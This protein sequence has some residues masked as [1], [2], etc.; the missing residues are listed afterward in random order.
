MEQ[1]QTTIKHKKKDKKPIYILIGVFVLF[2]LFIFLITRQ[3][4]LGKA[5]DQIKVCNSVTD[6]K[7]LFDKYKFD[8]L[9][10]DENGGKI[11]A[12][13]FQS[14]VRDKLNSFNL[15]ED[16]INECLE[17]LPPAQTNINLIVIPD[18]S[19]RITDSVNNPNQIQ[20][21]QLILNKIWQT[22]V[23]TTKLKKDSKDKI[24][25][26]VTDID[27]AKGQFGKFAN[28]LQFDLSTHKGQSNRLFFTTDKDKQFSSN[29]I[30]MYN[31]ARQK[32][33]GADYLF[34][35]RRYLVNHL[36]K[37]TLYDNYINKVIIITDG[38]LEAEDRAPDTKLTPQLYNSVNRS[39]IKEMIKEL[40]LNIP[41][42]DIDLSNTDVLV[43]EV[44]ERK[45]GKAKDFEILKAYWEDWLQRMG[46]NSINFIQREQA[47]DVTLKRVSDFIKYKKKVSSKINRTS[48]VID[49]NTHG[50]DNEL[51]PELE[52]TLTGTNNSFSE[53]K[54]AKYILIE[55]K[56]NKNLLNQQSANLQSL[57]KYC[58]EQKIS[59]EEVYKATKDVDIKQRLDFYT[60][61]IQLFDEK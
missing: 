59:A 23:E 56:Q 34:Y 42:V 44:N 1:Y 37:P 50:R 38:Y 60:E 3:S 32:P 12:L 40:G 39:D 30:A 31:S 36:K 28:S 22:F 8:L 9:E 14:A 7:S 53:I 46:A 27:Q 49:N 13:D 55:I 51:L 43:C 10:T 17:W 4:S 19:R 18:L 61:M 41:K 20:N 29:I 26:D 33:L 54:K 5:I 52:A 48:L 35:F 24:I 15:N 57:K 21:D 58:I 47:T 6:V 11:I 16:E 2:S 25:I 45:T